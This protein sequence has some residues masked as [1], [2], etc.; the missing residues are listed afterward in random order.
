MIDLYEPQSERP[1]WKE[2]V[3]IVP[4][5]TRVLDLGCGDGQLLSLLLPRKAVHAKGLEKDVQKVRN[6]VARGLS[7]ACGDVEEGLAKYADRSFEFVILNRI[8]TDQQI[9]FPVLREM[10]RVARF[11]IVSFQAAFNSIRYRAAVSRLGYYIDRSIFLRGENRVYFLPSWRA[12]T[13]IL[14]IGGHG[15][16]A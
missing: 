11:G 8:Q 13:A 1:D 9:P 6:C 16:H 15:T 14:V 3:N 10:M 7:V 4:A 5:G 2:I 12:E